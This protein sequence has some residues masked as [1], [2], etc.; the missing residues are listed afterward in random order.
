MFLCNH[1]TLIPYANQTKEHIF[2]IQVNVD[3]V[4]R[5]KSG[6]KCVNKMNIWLMLS[7]TVEKKAKAKTN[8][9]NT[10]SMY[11]IFDDEYKNIV[12][13]NNLKFVVLSKMN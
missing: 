9:N 5:T 2:Y 12:G 6:I 11:S 13:A 4:W 8:R 7:F 10:H 1:L 3:I